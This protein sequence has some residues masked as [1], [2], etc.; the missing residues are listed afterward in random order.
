M[1]D[2]QDAVDDIERIVAVPGVDVCFIAP[3]DLAMSYGHRDSADHPEVHAGIE[4]VERVASYHDLPEVEVS[5]LFGNRG[6][7]RG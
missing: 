3:F 1:L 4:K 6:L 7:F 5:A 2:E